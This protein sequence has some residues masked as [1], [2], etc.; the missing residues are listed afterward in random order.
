MSDKGTQIGLDEMVEMDDKE[1]ESNDT[2]PQINQIGIDVPEDWK[3]VPLGEIGAL[4]TSSVD[5]K[6]NPHEQKVNLINYMD[7]YERYTIDGSID[8]MEVTAPDSQTER[9]QVQLGDILFTPSSEEPGDIGNSA[10]VTEEMPDALHSYHTVRL[11]PADEST[12]LDVSFSGWL[13]NAPYVSKQFARRATGSTRYTLTLGDF[14]DTNVLVPPLPEQRKIATV[15]YTVD[16]AIEKTEEVI[17][18]TERLRK[19]AMQDIFS[20]GVRGY[21][22]FQETKYGTIPDNWEVKPVREIADRIGSGGTPNT[23]EE[24]YYGGDIEWVKT[25]DLNSGL[26]ESAKTTITSQGLDESAAKLFPVGTVVFAM[27]GG[28]LGQNGRLG[29]KAAM[30]QACCGIVTEELVM[31]SYLLHQQLIHRKKQLT[32]LSA[33]THQQNISQSMIEKFE[34]F[35]PPLNEQKE[36]VD[37]LKSI[38]RTIEANTNK[39]ERLKRLKHGLMQ[40]LLS[41]TVRTTDTDISVPEEITQY[42]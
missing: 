41:G 13:A 10:V 24:E 27:Y 11:R 34:V 9:S 5:K 19:G 15:L 2:H 25:D 32:A 42:G 35:V 23:D 40:D 17:T 12:S 16:R 22:D 20:R 1:D 26:V 36:I 39:K 4:D 21:D 37:I 14:S 33:G 3:S 31:N 38:E 18:Q 28:A 8:Y 29:M 6:S 7:V 30:N